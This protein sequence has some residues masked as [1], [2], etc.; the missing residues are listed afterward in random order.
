MSKSIYPSIPAPGN[1]SESQQATLNAM[2]QALTMVIMNAQEPSPNFT[3]SSA[4]QVFVTSAQLAKANTA[5]STTAS[6]VTSQ[7]SSI[8]TM[9]SQITTLQSQIATMQQ[10]LAT[11][12]NQVG[13]LNRTLPQDLFQFRYGGY[14]ANNTDSANYIA[15]GINLI[16]NTN[17]TTQ[18][19]VT[20]QGT[21]YND[22]LLGE[23]NVVL[24][25]GLGGAPP[26]FGTPIT[27]GVLTE[28][29]VAFAPAAGYYTP[30]AMSSFISGLPPS[31]AQFWVDFAV[32]V[33][34]GTTGAIAFPNVSMHGLA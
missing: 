7:G 18:F 33:Q 13:D 23:T 1:T 21:L 14:W 6:T 15:Q 32:L 8:Q 27:T 19:F 12:T 25:Y 16:G 17:K 3:P 28:P 34:S 22:T 5:A 30:F 20:A 11:L 9:Q 24:C 31:G 26:A 2:R 29:I 4:A 10:S